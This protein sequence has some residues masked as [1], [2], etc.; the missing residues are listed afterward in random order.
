MSP[1]EMPGDKYESTDCD[2]EASRETKEKLSEAVE[3][4]GDSREAGESR[5]I[6]M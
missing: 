4:A 2:F 1:A 5:G 3:A 6:Q